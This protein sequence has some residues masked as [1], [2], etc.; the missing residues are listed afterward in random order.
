MND[1]MTQQLIQVRFKGKEWAGSRPF[2]AALGILAMYV[3]VG[4]LSAM[5]AYMSLVG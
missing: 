2:G 3:R 4:D 1:G 5:S